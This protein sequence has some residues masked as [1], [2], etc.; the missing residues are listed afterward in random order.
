MFLISWNRTD[1]QIDAVMIMNSWLVVSCI[2]FYLFLY[3]L[4]SIY[5][6]IFYVVLELFL[7]A[8]SDVFH[9]LK[10]EYV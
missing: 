9:R 8:W 7:L 1:S 2:F 4:Y 6:Y 5:I 10:F 3:V